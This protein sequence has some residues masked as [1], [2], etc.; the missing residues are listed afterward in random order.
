MIVKVIKNLN[1]TIKLVHQALEYPHASEKFNRDHQSRCQNCFEPDETWISDWDS[2]HDDNMF[3][4]S[5]RHLFIE[6]CEYLLVGLVIYDLVTRAFGPTIDSY[7]SENSANLVPRNRTS[8]PSQ[9]TMLLDS[10]FI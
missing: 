10:S 3:W 9:Q 2:Q 1:S 8:V 5:L 6:A 7:S 4:M